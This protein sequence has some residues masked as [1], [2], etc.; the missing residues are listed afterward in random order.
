MSRFVDIPL[1]PDCLRLAAAGDRAA[2]RELYGRVAGPVFALIRRLVPQRAA[3]ED[4]FQDCMVSLLRHLPGFR[5]DAPFGAWVR[6]IALRHCLMHQRSPWQR[7]RRVLEGVAGSVDASRPEGYAEAVWLPRVEPPAPELIDLER[8]LAKLPDVARSVVWMYD[9]EGLSHEEIAVMF[10]R[11]VSFSKSQ[12]S[13][14]HALLRAQLS[15][16]APKPV[17]LAQQMPAPGRVSP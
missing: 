1:D 9:V 11:T 14:A 7:A 8:A 6:Q 3:A 2:Q 12:L 16:A 15:D 13:R 5:G 10:G 17:P 4:V